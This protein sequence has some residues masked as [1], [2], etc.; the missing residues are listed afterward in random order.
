[1]TARHHHYLSQCYLK[2]FTNG[3]SKKSKLEV[4]DVR[5]KKNFTTIP[6]NIG[7]IRDFNRIDADGL[8]PNVLEKSLAAFEGEVATAL[9]KFDTGCDFDGEVKELILNLIAMFASRSPERRE[10]MRSFQAQVIERM[11]KLSI[12]TKER[13]ESQITQLKESDRE[14][15]DVSY[16]D[17]KTFVEGKQYTIDVARE[18]HIRMESVAIEAILPC[19]AGRNW[20]VIK[21]TEETGPFITSDHP[22]NLSW[23]EPDSIPPFYRNSPGFGLKDTQVCFPVSQ[24]IALIG[25]FDGAEGIYEGTKDL[26]AALNTK[27]LYF[28]HKQLYAPKLNFYC[29][30]NDGELING[31][32]L[33]KYLH[34]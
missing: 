18:H 34:A 9:K 32:Q 19:L 31:K 14:L 15:N 23:K 25:E 30:N 24:S 28:V 7:G 16:E 6:R 27:M 8:D 20:M 5:K 29:H 21:S 12:A 4:I 3:G 10:H 33:L 13:W 22:V 2:G 26:V 17:I 11:M 1:M